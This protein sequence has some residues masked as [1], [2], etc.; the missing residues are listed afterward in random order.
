MPKRCRTSYSR[1][2]VRP[3]DKCLISVDHDITTTTV[4]TFINVA[5]F[6]CTITGIRWDLSAWN[7][8][9]TTSVGAWALVYVP[10]TEIVANFDLS[11]GGPFYTPEQNVLAFGVMNFV[12]ISTAGD[13][14]S[15][16]FSGSTKT[17]RKLKVGDHIDFITRGA[18][19]NNIDM[20]GII[21]CFCMT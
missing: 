11:D 21:Q 13:G 14:H 15:K 10:Q 1:R 3:I 16:D 7:K 5:T 19:V 9:S 12:S 20:H 17:M 4:V 18:Q 6:P 8:L 2:T